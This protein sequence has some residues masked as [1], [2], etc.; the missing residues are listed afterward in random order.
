MN[1]MTQTTANIINVDVFIISPYASL[2]AK[3]P[4]LSNNFGL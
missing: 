2:G 4:N 3:A 1:N